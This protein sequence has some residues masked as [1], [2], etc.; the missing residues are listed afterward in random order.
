MR[1]EHRINKHIKMKEQTIDTLISPE[2]HLTVLSRT[3]VNKLLDTSQGGLY[4]LL[5]NCALAVLN[6]GSDSDDG[7]EL[8]ER[9]SDFSI[10]VIQEERGIKLELKGAPAIAW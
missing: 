5:H 9:F 10:K 4:Q 2:V 3:E 1:P 7:K 6:C 8:L